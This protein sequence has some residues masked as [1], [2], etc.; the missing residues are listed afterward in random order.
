MQSHTPRAQ[1]VTKS[2]GQYAMNL[3]R[4]NLPEHEELCEYDGQ[5][6]LPLCSEHLLLAP[7]LTRVV[8]ASNGLYRR[9]NAG[10][11]QSREEKQGNN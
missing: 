5:H 1:I 7:A 8:P 2:S 4:Y 6:L 11:G 9:H 10:T 3:F